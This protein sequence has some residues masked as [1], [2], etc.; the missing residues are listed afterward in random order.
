M[1]D[2]TVLFVCEHGAAKSVIA[3]ELFRHL[4]RE[5]GLTVTCEAAGLEP[6]EAIPAHVIAGLA[7]DGIEITNRRPAQ[8][9]DDLIARA[10]RVATF[11]CD[12]PTGPQV[13]R[14]DGVPM[15][16]DGY[17]PARTAIAERVSSLLDE[18][19]SNNRSA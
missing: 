6:D 15:V 13:T 5:R 16:S 8:V 14:W 9:T 18:I 10:A 19:A 1:S 3:A 4:A 11:G 7:S 12:V 17:A 2:L